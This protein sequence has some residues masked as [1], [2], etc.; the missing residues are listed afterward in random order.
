MVNC[1]ARIG[2]GGVLGD[3]PDFVMGEKNNVG[4]NSDTF[5]SFCKS[6]KSLRHGRYPKFFEIQ[7]VH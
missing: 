2:N 1:N 7:V 3:M 5:L 6:M 4:G